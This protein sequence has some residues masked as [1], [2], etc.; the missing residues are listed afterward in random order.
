MSDVIWIHFA[1]PR[2]AWY[3]QSN[4]RREELE[5]GWDEVGAGSR[6]QGASND[7]PYHVRGQSDYSTV[8][9][10][11]FEQVDAALDHWLR[12]TAA[13]YGQWFRSSNSL[14]AA[15]TEAS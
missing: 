2:S 12:L 11:H 13:G 9:V 7:G 5:R 6:A 1:L 4:E 3:E 15:L 14:G 8:E 10:W